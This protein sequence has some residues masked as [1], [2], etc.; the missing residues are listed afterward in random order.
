[1]KAAEIREKFLKF[2]ES[3]GHTIVRSSSLV[4]GNDPT[5]MF[6]NSG[7]VQFKDVFLGTDPR[8]YSR[9]TTAQ[10]SVRA[11]GKHND[12]ENVGYTARHHTFFEMLGNFS[13]GDYFKHD[14]IK[15]AWELLTTVYQLPKEKLWVT[16]YQEDDEAYDIWAKEVGVPTER[17]I[18]IG[19]NKGARYAS[20][21][22]WTMGDT[23]PCGPCTEIFYDHGP[24]VWGGPPGSP[25]ED[26]DRYIEI[27][28]LVFMQF[29]RDAQGNM[30]RLPKQSV[31]TGMG[32]ERLAAVLQHVH[33]NY[34]ID[35]FQNLIKAAARVTEISD[36][37][38]NSLKVIADHIRACSFLIVDGV[39][40]GNEGR[41]YVLRRIVRRA[42]RHGYK[43]GRKG[44]FFHKL[45]ADLVAEMGTAYPELKEA[46]QR[47]TDVLRQ[48]EERFFETIEHGMSILEAALADVDA[49]G[50]K[51]LDG[52]LAF[53][54]HDTYG[55]PLDL[56]A[57]VCR[58]RGMTVD[59]PAFDDAMARQR[60]QARAAGKFKATQGLE[61]S[62]A[63]TTFH[64]Y[65]EIA[66][67]DAKVVAL[68]VD[69]SAVNEV[70]AGQD[71][72][73]VLDH[74]PFYAESGGQV[75]DQGVL[76]NAA[77]RFAV[78][79]TLKVQADVIGHHGTLE[80]GTLKVGDVLR[81]EID[82]QRRARTQRNHSA[83]HLMHKA[84]REVL[85]A[86]VQQKG[87]LVDAE[88]TRFDFAHN[89]PM[90][91]DEIRRVEQIVNNEILANAPGIVRVMPY[92]E[93]V[94]GGAMA[95]FGEKYGDEVRVLDLGFSRELCGGTHV[96]RT[97]DIGLFKIVVEGGVAA[98]IRRV[99]AITG[100]NAVRYVQE[101]D[102]RVNEAAA[103]L[104]AQ[105][106]E[107]TQRIAQVQDQVKS[108]EKELGALKSKLASSQ[109]D[110]LAQQ[111]VEIGGVYVL[112]ATLDGA[113]A[114]TLRE[115]VDKLK[116][117]L[118]SAAIVLAAVEGGKVSLIAGVTPDA[119][120]KVK[121]GE[122]V[123]FVAQQVGGKGGGRPDM[124]Q[125]GGTEPANLPGALA[126]VKGWVE[127]RL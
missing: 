41:G 85:G 62:G 28:N 72:V 5:L 13:F 37:T 32:L 60:E 23:G 55:F 71:A 25:E 99:E 46:E 27:W 101:L 118:K 10:R 120:K 70:K 121:A 30:T 113:D 115:T 57:D 59:E 34:E 54:L 56:T 116:D 31:D 97:G 61:Y 104:K 123:N 47:V 44:A 22:F 111:A 8:P 21:N 49:K 102:A 18:R 110:E 20:D 17:I 125:A 35:L 78:A 36:L 75:G 100:D 108:L 9:A 126:G 98:G 122:L 127:E 80:Q 89:A 117:K 14:A 6:T 26:G 33:S 48:E 77:T 43:L 86:H 73:V 76:A 84:L 39:I 124:A 7:M 19:D 91:D 90:T 16:V 107:L 52:E 105:P 87:S 3:K 79:D 114:K 63:K 2:F 67:D 53:K 81:A 38:N 96:H 58:E 95:L 42:I 103:A 68:Y 50:G 82:A 109:G 4:P 83:T 106:S 64:G 11:G 112:A 94:K 1:M 88:K 119:S 74:T 69:G 92:D 66:F 93:A 45:V 65:E 12:L 24:D 51:V 15:F 40:P 29:N